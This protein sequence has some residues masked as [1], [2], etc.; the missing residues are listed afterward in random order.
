MQPNMTMTTQTKASQPFPIHCWEL[1]TTEY[2][3][4]FRVWW[5]TKASLRCGETFFPETGI[6]KLGPGNFCIGPDALPWMQS[7]LH[8]APVPPGYAYRPLLP[9]TIDW[10]FQ[11]A[12]EAFQESEERHARENPKPPRIQTRQGTELELLMRDYQLLLAH[13][14]FH[15]KDFM[16]HKDY[17]PIADFMARLLKARQA[18]AQQAAWHERNNARPF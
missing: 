13:A 8:E 7:V 4:Q 6:T 12:D 5:I 17:P 15:G 9:E 14:Q 16:H 18:E 1:W 3:A 10:I 2:V 11:W